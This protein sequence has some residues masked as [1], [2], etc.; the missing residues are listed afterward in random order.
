MEIMQGDGVV[1]STIK[2]GGDNLFRAAIF[3]ET[4]S[5]LL[6]KEIQIIDTTGA[7]GAARAAGYSNGTFKSFSDSIYKDELIKIYKPLQNKE[8]YLK[9]YNNWKQELNTLY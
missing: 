8:E 7:T 6:G 9:A 1:L 5:T 4:I 2:A 3:S